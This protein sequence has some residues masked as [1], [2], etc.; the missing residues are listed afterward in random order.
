MADFRD[1]TLIIGLWVLGKPLALPWSSIGRQTLLRIGDVDIVITTNN[2][3]TPAPQGNAQSRVLTSII[4]VNEWAR[5]SDIIRKVSFFSD[6]TGC[7][8]FSGLAAMLII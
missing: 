3:P 8:H 7:R 4:R 2:D 5:G 6:P 1:E